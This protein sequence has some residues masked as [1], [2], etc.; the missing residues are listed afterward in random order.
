MIGRVRDLRQLIGDLCPAT[1]ADDELAT[2]LE[3]A[4]AKLSNAGSCAFDD[5][6]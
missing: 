2:Q 4:V 3:A 5:D 6:A 1:S